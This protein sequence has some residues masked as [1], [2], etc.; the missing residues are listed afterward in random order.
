MENS[1]SSLEKG[2]K[3]VV[4]VTG[5]NGLIGKRIVN[6]L[7]DKYQCIGLDT[8]G[9]PRADAKTENICLDIGDP[10]SIE[11]ALE[12]VRYAYG[13]EISSVIHLAAYYDF[14]GEPSP[15]Y[16]KITV[17]GTENL[18]KT[19]QKFQVK[20]FVFSSTNLVY[21]PTLPGE[22]I[23]EE[24]PTEPTWDYPESKV[25][26]E[27][28]IHEVRGKIPVVVLRIA[29]VYNEEGNSIPISNQ[30][31][32][33][34]EKTLTSHFY[35]GDLMHGNAFVHLDDLV[36]A[37]AQTV[38]KRN[39]LPD[40]LVLNISEPKTFGYEE[41]QDEIGELI[42]GEEW[43]TFEIPKP[44]AKAGAWAQEVVGDSF[45]KPWMIDRADDHFEMDISRAREY[46]DWQP[47]N[48]LKS[49]MPK[50]IESLKA[51]PDKW[52]KKNKLK[53]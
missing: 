42:H 36:E 5:A 2:R 8:K 1:I 45:I 52:Y 11:A 25:R 48:N 9:N 22:K 23:H 10:A 32:R 39:E 47:R 49:T 50:I 21:K 17:K 41:L 19:L 3:P 26:T 37:L 12:R 18:L 30:I 35:P 53:R 29:G 13:S 27:K 33:I 24:W 51:N 7:A 46:L 15:L 34:Y 16:E 4:L 43:K 40:E 14:A 38:E 44:L 28:I 31:Q 20:Q 6:R